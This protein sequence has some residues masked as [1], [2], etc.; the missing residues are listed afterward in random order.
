[1]IKLIAIDLDGTLLGNSKKIPEKNK[2]ALKKAQEKGHIVMIATGRPLHR[3]ID[4]AREVELD[5]YS[6]LLATSNGAVIT[7]IKTGETI[8]NITFDKG[9][10]NELITYLTNLKL[11]FMVYDD[12]KIYSNGKAK[13]WVK[14][15][16]KLIGLKI[17]ENERIILDNQLNLNKIIVNN[18]TEKLE[19]LKVELLEK[20]GEFV[21]IAFSSRLSL[22]IMPKLASK[23]LAIRTISNMM[24]ID[25]KDT[26]AFGN[27]GNDESMIR[28]ANVGVAVANS[29]KD[30][31]EIAD[32]VTLSNSKGG[33]GD[34]IEKYILGE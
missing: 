29:T 28:V 12:S 1:M 14:L 4:Y 13:F 7:N 11:D 5:K 30:L 17:I 16:R 20:F 22:E 25:M 27:T 10:Q 33:V 18:T 8:Q 9:L 3:A 15:M 21:D 24:G 31:L 26:I 34:Y 2:I 19:N 23:G 32:Y 6:G